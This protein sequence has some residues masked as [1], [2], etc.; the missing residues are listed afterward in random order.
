MFVGLL[1]AIH[2]SDDAP[3]ALIATQPFGAASLI[4]FQARRL[5]AA[6]ASHIAVVVARLT[7]ELI[8]AI[9]RIARRGIAIDSVRTAAEAC[10]K[11][12]PLAQI[13]VLADGLIATAESVALIAQSGAGD[14]L[15]V[16]S[17]DDA[18]PGMERVGRDTIWAGL[19]LAS[20]ARLGEVAALPGEYD[21][22]SS[23]LR[24]MAQGG[25]ALVRLPPG[26]AQGGHA[27]A[28][29]AATLRA[30]GEQ[31]LAARVSNPI[32]WADR[33]IVAPLARLLLRRV[34]RYEG[35]GSVLAGAGAV[36]LLLAPI[37]GAVG[38]G[39]LGLAVAGA[40]MVIL[41]SGAAL[42]W[43][44]DQSL[45]ARAQELASGIGAALAA[46]AIG[47]ALPAADRP[48]ALLAAAMLVSLG[49]LA[50]RAATDAIRKAWWASPA[51][52]LLVLWPFVVLGQPLVGLLAA[53]LYA[54]VSLAAAI[55]ALRR[56][57]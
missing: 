31:V 47:I 20:S 43:L 35:A 50:E 21:V 2:E 57:P 5:I 45:L 12:H 56:Q 18:L 13:L 52:L 39:G 48:L 34:A 16:T 54:G 55:E 29:D 28:W 22:Q 32:G 30:R 38:W 15:L 46:L 44:G 10:G 37:L 19:A 8:A 26:S 3:G 7:P 25:A 40:S 17:D 24:V 53:A 27:I 23:L 33:L 51:A 11:F 42:A 4:E 1:F 14:A 41:A 36:G 49:G 9:N 6:G